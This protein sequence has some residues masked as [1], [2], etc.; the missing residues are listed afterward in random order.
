[1]KIKFLLSVLAILTGVTLHAQKT[2]EVFS[3]RPGEKTYKGILS[4]DIL[5]ADSSFTWYAEN[6]EHY[7]TNQS[8]LEGL[9]KL[10]DSL[11]LLVFMGTW[12]EDSHN[13][14]PK[15]FSLCDQ[16]AFPQNHITL[17]GVDRN[18]KTWG[19]LCEA[20]NVDKVPTILLMKQ[21]KE[22]GRVVEFG[23]FGL[24]D[25]DLGTILKTLQ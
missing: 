16:A 22:L 6:L 13:V 18:K 21:G 2:Y 12:C 5:L 19:H 15:L 10:K 4:R 14:I 25:I 17:I 7:T 1:M 8:A 20:L 3:E 11:Q 24:F 23:K 9:R